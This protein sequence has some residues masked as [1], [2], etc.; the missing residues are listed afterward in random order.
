MA[1]F[2]RELLA[3]ALAGTEPDEQPLRHVAELPASRGTTAA[4]PIWADR[5]VITA[6]AER[7]VTTPWSHQVK[8]AAL[9]RQGRHVV[10]S[11]GTAS[12]KSL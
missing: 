5:E 7:G 9:A 2:G 10:I 3:S 6:F 1:G 8:A 4:W 12:G 11:T